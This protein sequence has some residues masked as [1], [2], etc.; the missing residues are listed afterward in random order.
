MSTP[1]YLPRAYKALMGWLL[2]FT[3]YL[4]TNR[5]RFG[6]AEVEIA[7]LTAK[8]EAYRLSHEKAD[9]PNAGKADRLDRE[10]KAL[11]VSKTVR[12]FVNARLRYNSLVTDDDRVNLGLNVPGT[13][14]TPAPKPETWPLVT[15]RITGP[16]IVRLEWHDSTTASKAKPPGVHGCEIR[17]AILDSPPTSNDDLIRSEFSTRWYHVFNF[18]E[19]KRGKTIYFCLRWEN[20]RGEKGPWSD[21]INTVIP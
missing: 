1:N 20:T 6:I 19:S 13:K 8:Y 5:Q 12:N 11:A 15:L 14:H 4:D 2:N 16:R 17:Y 18:D 7:D 10:E 3:S 21:I 9:S